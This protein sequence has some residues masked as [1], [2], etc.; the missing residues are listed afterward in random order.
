MEDEGELLSK[1]L[2]ESLSSHKA[3]SGK[4]VSQ[5]A[6]PLHHVPLETLGIRPAE[7][8]RMM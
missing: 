7:Y 1:Y 3:A 4:V 5:Y 8:Q 6:L 2:L